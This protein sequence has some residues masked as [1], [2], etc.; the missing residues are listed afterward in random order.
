MTS[1]PFRSSVPAQL[2]NSDHY[3]L[4]VLRR[5]AVPM[6]AYSPAMKAMVGLYPII[7]KWADV[8]LAGLSPSGSYAK[9]TAIRS[10]TD[11]DLFI[12]LKHDTPFTLEEIYWKLFEYLKGQGFNP[13][14]QNVSIGIRVGGTDI[15]LVPGRRQNIVGG[16]H[17]LYLRKQKSW[18]KTNVLRHIGYVK[19]HNRL[20][21][22]RIIKV[23]RNQSGFEFPSFYLEMAVIRAMKGAP[24]MSLSKRVV[25]VLEFLREGFTDSQFIDPANTNNIISDDLTVTERNIIHDGADRVLRGNWNEFVK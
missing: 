10:G 19:M 9:G 22:T 24:L 13:R 14:A 23:W 25:K 18:Q 15:D 16:D 11:I 4:Q 6:G 2:F 17:S 7:K 1:L 8:H 21:E 5:E 20:P 3:L 12:S